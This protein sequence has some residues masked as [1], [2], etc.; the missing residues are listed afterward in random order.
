MPA[1]LTEDQVYSALSQPQVEAVRSH[2]PIIGSGPNPVTDEIAAALARVDAYTAGWNPP[3][4]LL[5][6]WARD[7]AVWHLLKRMDLATE[8]HDKAR[9]TALEELKLVSEGKFPGIARTETPI[10]G[11]VSH[12]TREKII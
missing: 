1:T 11:T 10:T 4:A 8:N 12:G 6:A 5:T 3:A 2:W 9:E 7:L